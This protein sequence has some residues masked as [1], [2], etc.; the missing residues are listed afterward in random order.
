VFERP[1]QERVGFEFQVKRLD[2]ETID[3]EMAA[4]TIFYEGRFAVQVVGR[5]ITERKKAEK[6]I[7]Y[8]AFYDSLT[9]LPNRNQFRNHLN[10]VLTKQDNKML[11]VLFLDLDRF[12]IINDTKGHTVG[13]FILQ[14]VAN[15]LA[16]TVNNEGIVSRQG[17]DEFIILLEDIDKET[18][19]Q[20]AQKILT[21]FSK[22]L[23]VNEQEF[24]VTPSIGIS[25]YPDDGEDVETLIKNADTAMYQ[26]KE[27]GKNNFRIYSSN[28]NGISVR[29]ME[30]ENGLR[31]ALE[32]NQLMLHYQPQV[33]LT[34]GELVGIEALIRW[35]HP[36]HGL[37]AP[38]EFIPLA[39]ETGLIVPIG[40]WVLR[41][42]CRQR[43]AWES[44][45][46]HDFPVAVNVSV[47]QFEDDH[48][49]EYIS[50][51]L[52]EIG[53]DGCH[54]ELEITESIMQNL[55]NSTIIL[56]QLKGLGVLL[57]IDDFGTGYSSLSYLK[58][59]PIDKIKIDKSFVDDIIYHSNQG[60]MVKTII[61][62][63]L[64]LNFAVIAEGIETDEQLHFLKENE[65]KIGQGYFFSKPISAE[66]M[67][68]YLLSRHGMKSGIPT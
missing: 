27:R 60:I 21:E 39:E 3:V 8:M 57:S 15:R 7:Q 11:A 47:R 25:L 29:K 23:E 40:K 12:K 30:L 10:E 4:T 33:S 32:Q 19:T 48:L 55:E 20:I 46:F 59:L 22:P 6:T 66:Q 35:Q 54:L 16:A 51:V 58:H 34:T 1:N 37:I 36:E 62:M 18:V 64:N 28:L 50:G 63:G 26:A 13:D 38:S 61:D 56:N 45:G 65:C 24:F 44:I 49:I 42:A 31:K 68:E 2:G 67:D 53:L 52:D 43:K 5:D 17:G 9:G 14:K 41:E